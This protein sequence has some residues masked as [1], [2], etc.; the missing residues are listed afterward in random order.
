MNANTINKIVLSVGISCWLL[1]L[2]TLNGMVIA[3]QSNSQVFTG[4]FL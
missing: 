3:L 2:L 4:V 1:G